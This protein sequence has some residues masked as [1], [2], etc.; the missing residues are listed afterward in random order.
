MLPSEFPTEIVCLP[1]IF[2]TYDEQLK[3]NTQ[4]G[5]LIVW[6]NDKTSFNAQ[7]LVFEIY[8]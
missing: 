2:P 3:A 6:F 8:Y 4:S 5:N 1:P 7:L